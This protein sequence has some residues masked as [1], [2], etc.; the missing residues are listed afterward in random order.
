[1]IE[2][3]VGTSDKLNLLYRITVVAIIIRL[4]SCRS[5]TTPL[6][7]WNPSLVICKRS[8]H[9]LIFPSPE[10]DTSCCMVMYSYPNS[11]P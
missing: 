3:E 7:N 9:G 1:M 8:T 10:I 4:L 6:R 5:V 2:G 11:V